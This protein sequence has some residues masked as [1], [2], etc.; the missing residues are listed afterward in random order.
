[1][2]VSANIDAAVSERGR[3]GDIINK[4]CATYSHSTLMFNPK[5][6]GILK[7]VLILTLL[8]V[9]GDITQVLHRLFSLNA[10]I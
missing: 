4:C 10:N 8:Q 5:S 6:H 3:N 9:S 2:K 7:W 1:M